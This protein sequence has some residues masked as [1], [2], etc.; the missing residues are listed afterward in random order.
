MA[1]ILLGFERLA[2]FETRKGIHAM[3]HQNTVFHSLTKH[4]PWGKFE[5]LVE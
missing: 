2:A 4:V 5:R 3:L 1:W